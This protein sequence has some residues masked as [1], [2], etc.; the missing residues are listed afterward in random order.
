MV[1]C[2]AINCR[3]ES[4]SKVLLSFP[5]IRN[6]K[7]MADKNEKRIFR[8]YEAL[9]HL[10]GSL[11]RRLLPA[12]PGYK[13][14]SGMGSTFKPRRLNLKKD[15]V[16]TIFN[17]EKKRK[18]GEEQVGPPKNKTAARGNPED[19]VRPAFAKRRRLEVRVLHLYQL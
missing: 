4:K 1:F 16:P 12:K 11:H 6:T 5:R 13:D 10:Y 3:N 14:L 18:G 15:A 19:R 8:A 7:R 17:F 9:T 2:A